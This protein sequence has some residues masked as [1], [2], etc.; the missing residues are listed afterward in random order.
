MS[1]TTLRW[2]GNAHT[3]IFEIIDQTLLPERDLLIDLPSVERVWEAIKLLRVRGAPAIGCAAAYGAVI[4]ARSGDHL[5]LSSL[6]AA[7]AESADY[8][9]TSRPTAVN[10]FWALDRMKRASAA[11][12]GDNP[13]EYLDYLLAEA[14]AI[15]DEDDAMCHAIGRHGADPEL[16]AI[17]VAKGGD[18]ELRRWSVTLSGGDEAEA[19]LRAVRA[20]P[21]VLSAEVTRA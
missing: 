1:W 10:L 4:G 14:H 9:A 5:C 11:F 17:V 2:S 3:G 12:S 19:T 6:K 18:G 20:V 13:A 21:G 15:R 7:L 16:H 8:L